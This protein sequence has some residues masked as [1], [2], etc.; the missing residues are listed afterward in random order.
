MTWRIAAFV[1]D[2]QMNP[3]LV[4]SKRFVLHEEDWTALASQIEAREYLITFWLTDASLAG[5]RAWQVID[6]AGETQT[7]YVEQGDFRVFPIQYASGGTPEQADQLTL[8]NLLA[9]SRGKQVGDRVV[10]VLGGVGRELTVS[11]IYQ[12]ITRPPRRSS[13]RRRKTASE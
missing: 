6:P 4:S 10:T 11:G 1:R 12:G 8:P 2:I 3:A 13:P 9:I 5:G 7:I